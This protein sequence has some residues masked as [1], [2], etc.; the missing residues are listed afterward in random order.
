MTIIRNFANTAAYISANGQYPA[1]NVSGLATVATSGSASDITTGTLPS[2]VY[3]GPSAPVRTIYTS[4]ATWTKPATVKAVQ[5]TV[6]AGGGSG[7]YTGHPTWVANG[8]A[9]GAGGIGQFT[10]PSIPGPIA[11][12]VGAG[13]AAVSTPGFGVSGNAGGTSSFGSLI[14]A[15]GGGAGT[16][17]P[18][19]SSPGASGGTITTS[20][21]VWGGSGPY[22]GSGSQANG[23]NSF[24]QWG[25]GGTPSIGAS[26]YGAGGGVS[27]P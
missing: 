18:G 16:A 6:C 13:G 20:S 12:T 14:S 26:G 9:G 25:I 5:V 24:S 10:A 22:S 21:T 15:S 23:G 1:A 17:S 2:S 19:G 3:S 7:G 27:G 4:P 11:V 8:G